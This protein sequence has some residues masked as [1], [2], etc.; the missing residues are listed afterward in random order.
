MN[1]PEILTIGGTGV[2]LGVMICLA[3]AVAAIENARRRAHAAGYRQC[4]IYYERIISG[5]YTKRDQTKNL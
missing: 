1:W 2:F 3:W 5:Y 4:R